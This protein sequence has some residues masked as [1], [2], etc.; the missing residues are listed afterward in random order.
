L[1]LYGG[2]DPRDQPWYT[3]PEAVRATGLP[4]STLRA[5]TLGQRYLRNHDRGFFAPVISRPSNDDPRLSFSNLIEAH[6]LRALR[7][8]HEV[9][10][11]YVRDA[12]QV[13]ESEFGIDRLLISPDLRTSA[14]ELFL[15]HYTGLLE[16]SR[17]K[18]L[19]LRG[20]VK[21]FLKRVEF[22]EARLPTEFHP[23]GRMPDNSGRDVISL[24]PFVGFGRPLIKRLGISTQIIVARVDA[25][26]SLEEVAE[27]YGLLEE[28]IDEAI[29]YEA[30]A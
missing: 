15:D 20:V 3:Y 4:A 22:D 30:A 27:D 16:L 2:T 19:A 25:G 5:W 12:V 11:G 21:Q 1:E 9:K 14:G 10:L 6:V 7:T 13:A 24:S 29:L 23:F 26:E 8:V 18:Q 17:S 28:E